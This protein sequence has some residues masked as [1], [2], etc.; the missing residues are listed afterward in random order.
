MRIFVSSII[1]LYNASAFVPN[2]FLQMN[3]SEISGR[4][5]KGVTMTAVAQVR[6][7]LRIQRRSLCTVFP[8][9]RR[10]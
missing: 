6:C 4:T 10:D 2:I 3:G 8:L 5:P 9:M 7:R 1:P